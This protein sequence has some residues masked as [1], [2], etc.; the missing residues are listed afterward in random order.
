[1]S[2]GILTSALLFW[3][4]IAFS[5]RGLQSPRIKRTRFSGVLS[6]L[7]WLFSLVSMVLTMGLAYVMREP[8]EIA[9]GLTP[10]LKGLMAMTEGCAV[11]AALT[12]IACLIAWIKGYW[13]VTGR[14]HY[15]LVALAGIGFIWFL[16]YWNL[17]TFGLEGIV[18]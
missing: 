1:G 2:I 13:R 17:L 8:S 9:F 5:V 15:T 16:Y 7:A 11:L 10:L 6:C 3:P 18:H 12:V 4:A 14:L